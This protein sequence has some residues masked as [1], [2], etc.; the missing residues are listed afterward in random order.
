MRVNTGTASRAA[1]AAPARRK[2]LSYSSFERLVLLVA[3][4]AVGGTVAASALSG[5]ST[6]FTE[7]IG[8]LLVFA[9]LAAAV[10][11]GRNGGFLAAAGAT[12]VYTLM[13][14]PSVVLGGGLQPQTVQLVLVHVIVY[15]LVGVIGGEVCGR[16]KYTF[17]RLES[18]SALDLESRLYSEP[19]VRELLAS[20]IARYRRYGTPLCVVRLDLAPGLFVEYR[21]FRRRAMLRRVAQFV[22]N[23]VRL[24][25]D[26]GRLDDGAILIVLPS[27]PESGG[28]VVAAR[29][30]D[31]V[32]NLLQA[33]D[34]AVTS[35]LLS[36]DTDPDAVAR[37]VDD[38][39][40][41]DAPV[42]EEYDEAM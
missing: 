29:L 16:L 30:R 14:V 13:A 9:V 17:A 3:A 42:D 22:R 31:G 25:D 18:S 24:V 2:V 27:T 7:V 26:I 5:R 41:A 1:T 8:A 39:K 37:M 40:A 28:Q 32:S 34:D 20:G 4:V 38:L 21:P 23:D 36:T 19:M 15:G 11:W 10:H 35:E 12:L 33:R 6:S